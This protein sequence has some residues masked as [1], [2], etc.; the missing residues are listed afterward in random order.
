MSPVNQHGQ[1]IGDSLPAWRAARRLDAGEIAGDEL[2]LEP[3]DLDRQIGPLWTA[4]AEPTDDAI[5][6]YMSYGPFADAE[7]FT[8]WAREFMTTTD[9][10]FYAWLVD[11]RPLGFAA[12]MGIT[13]DHGSI[14]IG[15]VALSRALR[16]TRAA[17]EGFFLMIRH[18]FDV[19]GYRRLEWKCDALNAPSR[20]AAERL[21]F[22]FEGCFRQ[23]LVLKGRSRDTAWYSITDGEWPAI[24]A[25]F[26]AWL[27]AENFDAEGRQRRGLADCRG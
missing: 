3:L 23:H 19:L 16:R 10:F 2:G 1:P 13:P 14:E 25:G 17:T 11:G 9:P 22:T 15:H 5:W 12:F 6:T 18:A 8:E 4:F 21:G 7:Q 27:R 26:D 24:R 20:A